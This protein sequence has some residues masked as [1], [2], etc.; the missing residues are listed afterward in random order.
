M[1]AAHQVREPE[2]F[3]SRFT[4]VA[5]GATEVGFLTALLQKALGGSLQTHGITVSDASGH[6]NTIGL[7]EALS[8]GG[9]KFGGLAD[10]EGGRY[11]E[12]WRRIQ[13]RLGP[14]LFRWQNGCL[15]E[16]FIP[17]VPAERIE[18]LIAHPED[19]PGN[20]LR[21]LAV[22]LGIE[23]KAIGAI[24]TAAGDRLVALI[25]EAAIGTVPAGKE[26]ERKIYKNH[27]G[28][29]FK[30][31]EGGQEI[32]AK[33]F[34]MGLWPQFRPLLM[35]FLNAIRAAIALPVIEDLP[36]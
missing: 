27:A 19:G 32:A 31:I 22:R 1:I 34:A 12:R 18:E 24:R 3:L 5:E 10:N 28:T 15:E 16:N 4:I 8:R 23:D 30:S 36:Q 35:P 2:A 21:T 9:L 7:L 20:R 25:I 11:P 13:E 29:W 33:M 26:E 17:T 6:D 14:L